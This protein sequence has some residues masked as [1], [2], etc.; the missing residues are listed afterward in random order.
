MES[1]EISANPT[2]KPRRLPE[3]PKDQEPYDVS[4]VPPPKPPRRRSR[5]QRCS[6]PDLHRRSIGKSSLHKRSKSLTDS[7]SFTESRRLSLSINDEE[8]KSVIL[9]NGDFR[10]KHQLVNNQGEI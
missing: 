2:P 6:T 7:R 9:Q 10:K 4:N 1:T 8:T 3:I 5:S